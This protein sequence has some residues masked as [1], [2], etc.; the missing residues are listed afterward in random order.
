VLL[1]FGAPVCEVA[2][3]MRGSGD[4][5]MPGVK[6]SRTMRRV[7]SEFNMPRLN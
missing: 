2:M 1:R 4:D 6:V 7:D 3:V 5:T